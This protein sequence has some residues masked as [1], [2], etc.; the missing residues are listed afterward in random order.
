MLDEDHGYSPYDEWVASIAY[1]VSFVLFKD[2]FE[3]THTSTLKF[4]IYNRM[5]FFS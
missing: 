1:Y 4:S 2:K 5:I 3:S